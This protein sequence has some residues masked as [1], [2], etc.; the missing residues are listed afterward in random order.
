MAFGAHVIASINAQDKVSISP[1]LHAIA[2]PFR[3]NPGIARIPPRNT[4]TFSK[5]V[6]LELSSFNVAVNRHLAY[7]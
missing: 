6:S 2:I 3:L 5:L 7:L 1:S 4:I